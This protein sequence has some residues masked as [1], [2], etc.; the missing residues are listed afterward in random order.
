M[1]DW[2]MDEEPK[3]APKDA[4]D[5]AEQEMIKEMTRPLTKA[6]F[7]NMNQLQIDCINV[8]EKRVDIASFP[9]AYQIQIRNYYRFAPLNVE[10]TNASAIKG[11]RGSWK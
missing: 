2:D 5:E 6:D 8:H 10:S 3:A 11:G 4:L 7:P 9:A 1:N